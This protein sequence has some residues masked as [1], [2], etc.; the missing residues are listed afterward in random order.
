M[1]SFSSTRSL[2]RAMVSS[3][4]MSISISFPVSVFTL[5]CTTRTR[6]ETQE[7]QTED[8]WSSEGSSPKVLAV[9]CAA[10]PHSSGIE[11]TTILQML[12]QRWQTASRA[13]STFALGRQHDVFSRESAALSGLMQSQGTEENHC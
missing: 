6:H 10:M 1:P 11:S 2:M 12:S 13:Q 4:S 8:G 9:A 3:D 5:I 7:R